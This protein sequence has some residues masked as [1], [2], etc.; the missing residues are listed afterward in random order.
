M[1][2]VIQPDIR[3]LIQPD[4]R[5]PS[6]PL[7][8]LPHRVRIPRL[9]LRLI[10]RPTQ[11]R[12]LRLTPLLRLPAIHLRRLQHIRV[13][14]LRLC[15]LYSRPP[16]PL[17]IPL[18]RLLLILVTTGRMDVTR[19]LVASATKDEATAGHAG[20]RT[21]TGARRDVQTNTQVILA[22]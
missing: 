17:S 15:L 8:L 16:R 4:I 11:R 22:R 6:L 13:R 12:S 14:I 10:R 20:V 19:V 5:L 21:R 1:G 3:L 7:T 2:T 9:V 18:Q